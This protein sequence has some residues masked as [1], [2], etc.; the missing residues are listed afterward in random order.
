[1][2]R[3]SFRSRRCSRTARI[4]W[5]TKTMRGAF[6][7][8][9][10][11]LARLKDAAR[12]YGVHTRK[13]ARHA[14]PH[15]PLRPAPACSRASSVFRSRARIPTTSSGSTG[16]DRRRAVRHRRRPRRSRPTA[17][18]TR[19]HRHASANLTFEVYHCP[20]HTPGHVIFFITRESRL[21]QV[22]DVLFQGSIGRTDFPQGQPSGAD[23]FDH[24]SAVA[25][26]RAT[27]RS[28]RG[29]VRCRPSA[30][31]AH[32]IRSLPMRCSPAPDIRTGANPGRIA[33]CELL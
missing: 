8:P 17:G 29:T 19:R 26:G 7:D 32:R 33:K 23:R 9:G 2:P 13:D 28:F 4:L 21:A 10:G 14:R 27:R 6:V 11:D 22:G 5:C 20:G 1:M 24:R 31:S 12:Q 3:P 15:R 30:T 16:G 25:A 18:S